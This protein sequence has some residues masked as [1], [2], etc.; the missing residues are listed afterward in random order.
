MILQYIYALHWDFGFSA[1]LAAPSF[2]LGCVTVPKA[3]RGLCHPYRKP[4]LLGSLNQ[5]FSPKSSPQLP[6]LPRLL[7]GSHLSCPPHWCPS[8]SDSSWGAPH[9]WGLWSFSQWGLQG[10]GVGTR[11]GIGLRG[12]AFSAAAQLAPG[13]SYVLSLHTCCLTYLHFCGSLENA[14]IKKKASFPSLCPMLDPALCDLG[15]VWS[16]SKRACLLPIP[17]RSLCGT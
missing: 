7:E 8:S 13:T 6:C 12:A 16:A 11:G 3:H 1:F 2:S 15:G 5:P 17:I 9:P 14:N 10:A 4:Q